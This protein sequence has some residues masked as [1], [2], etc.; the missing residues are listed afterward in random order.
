MRALLS[1]AIG[2]PETLQLQEIAD[3]V[4]GLGDVLIAVKA[5]G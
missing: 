4:P 1:T 2:G 3:P 5:V